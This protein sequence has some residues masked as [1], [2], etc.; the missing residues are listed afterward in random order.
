MMENVWKPSKKEPTTVKHLCLVQFFM[1]LDFQSTV[2]QTYIEEAALTRQ[3][4]TKS[5]YLFD[6]LFRTIFLNT[7]LYSWKNHL[8]LLFLFKIRKTKT[9][10]EADRD[11]LDWSGCKP[12]DY[13]KQSTSV[14]ASTYSSKYG[15][16]PVNSGNNTTPF[17]MTASNHENAC[18]TVKLKR[19]KR[20]ATTNHSM[21]R[22]YS[23]RGST[24][25]L[26]TPKRSTFFFS[27]EMDVGKRNQK[28]YRSFLFRKKPLALT[29]TEGDSK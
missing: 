23:M 1:G 11:T 29:K 18:H 2:E 22:S 28:Y 13:R 15:Q 27:P 5:N 9:K 12:L 17:S 14:S 7:L 25:S 6:S 10:I 21:I 4:K 24:S 19:S 20:F 16:T 8:Y 3:I 26:A